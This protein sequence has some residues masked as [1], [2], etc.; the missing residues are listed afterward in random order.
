MPAATPEAPAP[1]SS[2]SSTRTR[3][4]RLAARQAQASPTTP[5]PITTASS[6]SGPSPERDLRSGT[7]TSSRLT[8]LLWISSGTKVLTSSS[9][10]G[11]RATI[12]APALPGSGSDGRR[13]DAALSARV[14]GAPVV[15]PWYS[16]RIQGNP[17]P[18]R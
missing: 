15:S 7:T 18:D 11:F 9:G 10:G 5:A 4:P 1:G 16:R 8:G 17:A 6:A 2:R 3:T 14:Y 12:P 13:P